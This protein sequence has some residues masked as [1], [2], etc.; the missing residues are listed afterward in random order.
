MVRYILFLSLYLFFPFALNAQSVSFQTSYSFSS[1]LAFHS[2]TNII[3]TYDGGYLFPTVKFVSSTAELRIVKTQANGNLQWVKKL[4]GDILANNSY[5]N[6][7]LAQ[8]SDTGFA[9]ETFVR[10]GNL[11]I[12][13][14]IAVLKMDASGN[15][16]WQR[17]FR[18][19]FVS[20]ATIVQAADGSFFLTGTVE[21][22]L[23][24]FNFWV[25]KVDA[26]GAFLWSKEFDFS[27]NRDEVSS[28]TYS[29]DGGIVITGK[30]ISNDISGDIGLIKL[31]NNGNLI[32]QK[33]LNGPLD[34]TPIEIKQA[35]NSD[36]VLTGRS[37]NPE[38]N[39]GCWDIS[40][41][42]ININGELVWSY[43]YGG[44]QCDEGYS[45]TENADGT[46]AI[47]CE[48]E[49][50]I[51]VSQAA[52]MK[53]TASGN[54]MW[55]KTYSNNNGTFPASIINATDG[56]YALAGT[57]G[58]FNSGT[59]R[60]FLIKTDENGAVN[61]E[62]KDVYP[63]KWN[64]PMQV[65]SEGSW[66]TSMMPVTEYFSWLDEM[67]ATTLVCDYAIVDSDFHA[68]NVFTPNG[69]GE[70]DVFNTGYS[71]P[72]KYHLEIY[73]R[74]GVLIFITDDTNQHWNGSALNGEAVSDGT[75]YYILGIGIK[76]Y[77]GFVTLLH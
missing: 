60:L 44:N 19:R 11:S 70:N 16:I 74:W 4:D 38:P 62:A 13:S 23:Q 66:K 31:D 30:V 22:S 33:V 1:T 77:A 10:P 27:S 57:N 21:D 18:G 56:G 9:L 67:G 75:Y 39:T 25:A 73:D 17:T 6:S 34:D 41:I 55:M 53:I 68:P 71:G 65:Y 61:C 7:Y 48:P 47:A 26:T 37:G 54:I 40:V 72:E 32:W 36:Y 5:T 49:S 64:Y 12:E 46:W 24:M 69:N 14:G 3:S 28:A 15:T 58:G 29:V 76:K 20:S 42:R 52:I 2:R 45:L 35:A 8:T 59:L 63:L 43:Y 50:Y 51:G